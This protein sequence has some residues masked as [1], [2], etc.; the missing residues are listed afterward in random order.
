MFHEGRKGAAEVG[1]KKHELKSKRIGEKE[2]KRERMFDF[3]VLVNGPSEGHQIA[4]LELR[5]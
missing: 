3:Y 5:V 1:E 2:G 4:Y